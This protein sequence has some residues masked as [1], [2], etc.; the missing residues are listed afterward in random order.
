[1]KHNTRATCVLV[2]G[3]HRSGT[4]ALTRVL[5]TQGCALPATLMGPNVGNESGHW[6]SEAI[7]AFNDELMSSAGTSWD[8]WQPF[9]DDWYRSPIAERFANRARALVR[10][11]FEDAPLF[12]LKDPRICRLAKWW[13]DILASD[14]VDTSIIMPVRDPSEVAASLLRRDGTY[15]WTGKLL[16][17]RYVLDAEI[18]TRGRARLFT[19]YAQ[20]LHDWKAIIQRAAD[21]FDVVFPRRTAM[22][23]AEVDAFLDPRK[24]VDAEIAGYPRAES[25]DVGYDASVWVSDTFE[26]MVRW[27]R[28]SEDVAD[29][30]KLD[31]IRTRFDQVSLA[32]GPAFSVEANRGAPGEAAQLR[33][34]LEQAHEHL[35]HVE[36]LR[37]SAQE[38]AQ[39][40]HAGIEARN[41]ALQHELDQVNDLLSAR[42]S[43]AEALQ[44]EVEET[45]TELRALSTHASQA[46]NELR[47]KD[48]ALAQAADGAAILTREIEALKRRVE[49]LDRVIAARDADLAQSITAAEAARMDADAQRALAIDHE[50][51]IAT[52]GAKLERAFQT[53]SERDA[54][55]DILRSEVKRLKDEV[56][57]RDAALSEAAKQNLAR[58]SDTERLEAEIL[59]LNDEIASRTRALS[60][61]ADQHQALAAQ[62]A[63]YKAEDTTPWKRLWRTLRDKHQP[64][65]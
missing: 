32:L 6:E 20:L 58:Q 42:T 38:Q 29:H 15:E 64:E 11:E 54:E 55:A 52:Q 31:Q 25:D 22:S 4:S 51:T 27:A 28:G 5:N 2:L 17:L 9:N 60:S 50:A 45:R 3:A 49:E 65:S 39:Q 7:S 61:A 37:T 56:T 13:L 30:R 47:E 36:W 53:A 63:A 12:V 8:D 33:R 23:A 48:A 44:R 57:T 10:Q 59:R 46:E 43:Q 1:M 16:W 14:D 21:H 26:I 35:R 62:F 18:A 34:S 24:K 40:A 41:G 19:T